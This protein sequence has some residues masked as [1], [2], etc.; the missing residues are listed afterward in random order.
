M[1]KAFLSVLGLAA[2][3]VLAGAEEPK[4]KDERLRAEVVKAH[5]KVRAAAKLPPLKENPKLDA[6]ALVHAEDMAKR[7]HMSH[8]GSDGSKPSERVEGQGYRFQATAENVAARQKAVAEVMK[9]WM[10]S[11][12]HKANILGNYT[13]IGVARVPNEDGTYYWCTVFGRPW[14][15][16]DPDKAAEEVVRLINARR[17]EDGK[18]VLRVDAKLQEAAGSYTREMAE[19]DTFQ[20]KS[21]KPARL[22]AQRAQA[23]GYRFQA[24]ATEVAAATDTPEVTVKAWAGREKTLKNIL[25]DFRDIGVGVATNKKGVPYWCLLLAKP[26]K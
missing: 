16:L 5:N 3:L 6:A 9:G 2:T 18:P 21:D 26:A 23:A 13:E 15:E 4:G 19:H 12:G 1:M 22:P 8:E 10:N 17:E 11:P 20:P 24:V 7:D 14:A 25:G